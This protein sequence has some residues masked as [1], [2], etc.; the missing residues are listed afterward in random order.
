LKTFI[1]KEILQELNDLSVE[2]EDSRL[3]MI[4]SLIP[5][6]G[7]NIY[8]QTPFYCD[9]GYN[10]ELGDNVFFNFNCTVLDIAKVKI[11][12]R[13]LIGPNTQIYT[14]MHPIN[15]IERSSGLEYGK[16][17]VIGDDVWIG[18]G[19]IICPGVK[20]GDRTVIGAGSVVTKDMPS[21]VVAAGNP[22]RVIRE[23]KC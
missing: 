7:P 12:D 9:Y 20:N 11:G 6:S 22:C 16:P 4:Q 23:N 3:Q 15:H 19:V 13:V 21:D 17:I 10:I 1:Q 14:V 8:I 18:G 5:K 2:D